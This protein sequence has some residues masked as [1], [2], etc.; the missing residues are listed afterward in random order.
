MRCAP[1]A[2]GPVRL[3]GKLTF[4]VV[5]ASLW[6]KSHLHLAIRLENFGPGVAEDVTFHYWLSD[7]GGEKVELSERRLHETVLPVGLRREALPKVNPEQP[8]RELSDLAD[9][10]LSLNAGWSW[11]DGCG[12]AHT[13]SYLCEIA[14]IAG[15]Y[16]GSGV[17]IE[18]FPLDSL[19]EVKKDLDKIA[20]A[21][22]MMA[23][24]AAAPPTTGRAR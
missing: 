1:G 17:L 13:E 23:K 10:G 7:R 9:A 14:R 8:P 4:D 21:L 20:D 15:D 2:R 24:A 16:R 6:A 12:R 19:P 5:D 22:A 11:R 3:Y 18:H